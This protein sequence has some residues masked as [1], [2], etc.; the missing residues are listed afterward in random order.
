MTLRRKLSLLALILVCTTLGPA[1][2][3]CDRE[4][5]GA[6]MCMSL[7]ALCT[8]TPGARDLPC[9]YPGTCRSSSD[10]VATCQR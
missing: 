1:S 6:G 5:T 4:I 8:T 9:C 7:G 10:G 3:G 2:T